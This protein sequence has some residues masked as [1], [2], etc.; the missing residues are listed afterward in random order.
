MEIIMFDKENEENKGTVKPETPE[1]VCDCD[2]EDCECN[3]ITLE[4]EDGTEKD[5]TILEMLEHEGK[6]YMALT[7]GDSEEYDILRVEGNDEDLELMI[8]EDDAE[9]EKVADLF[10]A[11]FAELEEETE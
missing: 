8:I 11:A 6:T 7:E 3:T 10:D 9:Y 1:L 4:L 5:F 2:D